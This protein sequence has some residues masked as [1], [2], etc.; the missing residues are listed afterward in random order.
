MKTIYETGTF[1]KQAD[2]LWTEDER[3]AFVTY[4]SDNPNAGDVIPNAEGA[5]K[6][7]WTISGKGK[8]GGAGY[9]F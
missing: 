6:T 3:L 8:H 2:K 1:K 9:L 4:L 7:H 5:R